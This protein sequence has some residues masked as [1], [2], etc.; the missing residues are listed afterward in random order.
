MLHYHISTPATR[1]WLGHMMDMSSDHSVVRLMSQHVTY[2]L[3][4]SGTKWYRD[5]G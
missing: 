5:L 2:H 1:S 4:S 3:V